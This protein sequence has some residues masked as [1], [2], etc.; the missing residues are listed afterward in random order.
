MEFRWVAFMALWTLLSGPIFG[1]PSDRAAHPKQQAAVTPRDSKMRSGEES[2]TSP[3][4][5]D[6]SRRD[7]K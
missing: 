2:V 6:A 7:R 4:L 5:T 3:D 1:A